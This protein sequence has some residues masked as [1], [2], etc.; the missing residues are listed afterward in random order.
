MI[1]ETYAWPPSSTKLPN[2]YLIVM[3]S[4]TQVVTRV[5][6]VL[7]GAF[8]LAQSSDGAPATFSLAFIGA[9]SLC[10]ALTESE[11]FGIKNMNKKIECRAD[12]TLAAVL[13]PCSTGACLPLSSS[14]VIALSPTFHPE[15]ALLVALC[16]TPD[17]ST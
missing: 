3:Q 6:A 14:P 12:D 2:H 5:D 8:N 15:W 11:K 7:V 1:Y 17:V 9:R 4:L 16:A 10:C 13:G